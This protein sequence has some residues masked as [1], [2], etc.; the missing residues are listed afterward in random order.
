M[1]ENFLTLHPQGKNGVN[2][3]K[4]KYNVMKAAIVNVLQKQGEMTFRELNE[5]VGRQLEGNFEGSIGWYLTTV[6]LDLEARGV[7]ERF[8]KSPQQLR[9][10][11]NE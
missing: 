2:I 5:E 10:I 1:N 8:G 6:K 9:L 7:I 4:D 11:A 3:S